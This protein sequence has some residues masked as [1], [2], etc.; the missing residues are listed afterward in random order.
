M[1]KPSKKRHVFRGPQKS[2]FL[3]FWVG[4]CSNLNP[5]IRFWA[6]LRFSWGPEIRRN[7]PV[8]GVSDKR[9]QHCEAPPSEAC[10]PYLPASTRG[11]KMDH[12]EVHF[13]HQIL[14]SFLA[15]LFSDILRLLVPLWL[16]FGSFWAFWMHFAF[17]VGSLLRHFCFKFAYL[18]LTLFLYW[19]YID[20]SSFFTCPE[21][22]FSS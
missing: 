4:P 19:F 15:C 12:F 5:K 6:D 18:F 21:P 3:A 9:S 22:R 16:P 1:K 7:R 14:A 10:P 13:R 20:L 2:C 17:H 11:I 8:S